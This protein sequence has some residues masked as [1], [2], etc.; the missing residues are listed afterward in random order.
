MLANEAMRSQMPSEMAMVGHESVGKTALFRNLTG[1]KTVRESNIKGSTINCITANV[2]GG[3][4][5]LMDTPGIQAEG[6]SVAMGLALEQMDGLHTLILVVKS[7]HL[8]EEL[9]FLNKHLK[10]K[11]KRVAVLATHEDKYSPTKSDKEQIRHLLQVPVVWLNARKLNAKKKDKIIEAMEA[12]SSWGVSS[13]ILQFLPTNRKEEKKSL[14]LFRIPV[15]GPIFA[16]FLILA[17]FGIPVLAAYLFSDWIQPI[18]DTYLI[19]PITQLFTDYPGWLYSFIV[20]DY[21]V[22]TLGWYSFV[23]AF[24]VVVMVGIASAVMEETGI[25][26]HIMHTLDPSLRKIGLTGRDLSPVLTGFGC[27]VVA[28]LQSRSCSTCTRISCASMISI[29]SACSYQIGA[30]LSIFGA[31][32]HPFLFI[33]YI[34]LLFLV[35]AVHT[36]LWNKSNAGL[37]K[38]VSSLPYL[39]PLTWQGLW[40]RIKRVVMQFLTQA[41]PIF[42]IICV[43]ATLLQLLHVLD[44]L[45]VLLAPLLYLLQLPAEAGTG[46]LF[47]VIRKDGMLLFNQ[48]NGSLLDQL[49]VFQVFILVYFA[50][51]FS[52]CMVTLYTMGREFGWGET[53]GLFLKQ[54][55]TSIVSTLMLA[56]GLY[57]IL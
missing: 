42:L 5:E 56:L 15:L 1:D 35:G 31:A 51:T 19:G 20:G 34:V 8:V 49:Q 26:E 55:F 25:Q 13:S 7:E 48:G 22:I 16:W 43:V 41:M 27:N 2:Q 24:P 4:I 10:L 57:A 47:S 9:T 29:G 44:V 17:M 50:S 38:R 40:W 36:R 53:R 12:A 32:G 30:T 11:G 6:D 39:Q 23:W 54:A 28:V 52:S 45:A 14:K 33:P 37:L 18:S 21:G 46:I 3:K